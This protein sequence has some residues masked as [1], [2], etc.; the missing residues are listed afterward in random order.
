[1]CCWL[2]YVA[3]R[4][5]VARRGLVAK[6][7]CVARIGCVVKR[8]CGWSVKNNLDLDWNRLLLMTTK[9]VMHRPIL[10]WL[11]KG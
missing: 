2:R 7:G 5:C 8:V 10:C 9:R 3:R 6:R 1:M 11:R 4:G